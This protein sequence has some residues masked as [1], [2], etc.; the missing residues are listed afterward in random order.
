MREFIITLILVFVCT[1]ATAGDK[2]SGR[3]D[4][5]LHEVDIEYF[6]EYLSPPAGQKPMVFLVIAENG[7]SIW[8][9][10][11]YCPEGSCQVLS[12]AEATKKCAAG[13]EKYYK[14]KKNLECFIFAKR[15]TVVWDN[16]IN[17]GKSKTS[18]FKSKWNKAEVLEKFSELG[19][20]MYK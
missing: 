1:S 16:D 14:D 17:P 3:G 2:Y 7:K 15:K 4:L 12:K 5:K 8:S 13:A 18:S 19:F 10:Y 9:T 20:E 6:M 11:W